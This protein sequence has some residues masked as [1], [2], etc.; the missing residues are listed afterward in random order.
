MC[1]CSVPQ[2][3]LH[4]HYVN[5]TAGGGES[6]PVVG[7]ALVKFVDNHN[8]FNWLN[9]F[10]WSC[11]VKLSNAR[12]TC[13]K[14]TEKEHELHVC[15]PFIHKPMFNPSIT[16]AKPQHLVHEI[17]VT[18]HAWIHGMDYMLHR[19]CLVDPWYGMHVTQGMLGSTV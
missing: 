11:L 19:A 13:T 18:E 8:I 7:K 16:F 10:N 17:H 4:H 6:D 9:I 12:C 14:T 1:I 5:G 15:L 2:S 3:R